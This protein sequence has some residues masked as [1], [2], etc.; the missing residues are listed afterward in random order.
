MKQLEKKLIIDNWFWKVFQ[1]FFENNWKT[2]NVLTMELT[3]WTDAVFVFPLTKEKEII[4]INEYR[5]WPE[6][7]MKMFPAWW[8][9]KDETSIKAA[10]RELFEE[11]WYKAERLV[12]LWAYVHNWYISWVTNLYI[13]ILCE[14]ISNQ[15]LEDIEE[16][17]VFKSN[18]TEFEEMIKNNEINCPWTELA[19]RKAK[20]LT[21]N[22]SNFDF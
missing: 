15:K 16:I 13:W 8:V 12:F 9:S 14:K 7:F 17:E 11:T 1:T 18:I 19:Y 6:K 21:N 20:E 2:W 5:F 22:F 3:K 10:E 4:Y